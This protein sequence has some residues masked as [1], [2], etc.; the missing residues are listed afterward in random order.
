[1][2]LGLGFRF[3]IG[4]GFRSGAR[5][6]WPQGPHFAFTTRGVWLGFFDTSPLQKQTVQ[7][8]VKDDLDEFLMD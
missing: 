2:G 4:F 6:V 7:H 3:R 8:C 1:M 5:C